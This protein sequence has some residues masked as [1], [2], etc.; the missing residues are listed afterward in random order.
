MNPAPPD[1]GPD[2]LVTKG[3]LGRTLALVRGRLVFGALLSALSVPLRLMPYVALV[4]ISRQLLQDGSDRAIW[5]WTAVGAAG[6]AIGFGLYVAAIAICHVADANFKYLIRSRLARHLTGVRLGWFTTSGSGAIKQAMTDDVKR[7]HLLVA[8]LPADLIPAVLTP[9]VSVGYLLA[10]DWRLGLVFVGYLIA[11]MMIAAPAMSR[12]YRENIAAWNRSTSDLAAAA[13]ELGDGIEVVKSYGSG[14]RAFDRYTRAVDTMVEVCLRWMSQ[15]GRSTSLLTV[16]FSP[17]SMIVFLTAAGA[18]MLPAGWATPAGLV[19]FLVLGLG[20]PAAA[21]HIGTMANLYREGQLGATRI[22]RVF[23][24]PGLPEPVMPV[25][26][27]GTDIEFDAVSF[28]YDPGHPV[29]RDV[30]FTIPAG[31]VTAIVG[32]SGSGKT[33]LARLLPRFWD[34]DSG[35]IRLGGADLRELDSADLLRT[36]AIVFQDIA[37][38]RD[39][40]RENIRIGSPRAS[41]D[42][43]VAAARRAQIHAVIE[44]L[45]AGYDTVLG[46]GGGDLSGGEQQRITIA[47]AIV[48]NPRIVILDEAT[49][50]ADPHSEAAVQRALGELAAQ[51]NTLMVIAHRLH[52]IRFADQIVVLDGGRVV[53]RGTHDDLVAQDG[54]YARMWRAQQTT[55]TEGIVR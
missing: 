35:A 44:A 50:H 26:P 2:N 53:Q 41:D 12:G 28:G 9:V 18:A 15:M 21:L 22:G 1:S 33:T 31:T 42:D 29:L 40:V 10:V 47:R 54:L 8:H 55:H 6:A 48:Q 30:S 20:V 39:T 17:A 52:T 37:L 51:G 23:A 25:T 4:E 45:P 5:V 7:M 27:A 43:V 32:P 19:A 46:A 3:A 36:M 34:V 14:A 11:C 49:A 24:E 38:L 13:V 16:L